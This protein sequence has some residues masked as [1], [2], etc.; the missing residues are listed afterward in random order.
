MT[1][2]FGPAPARRILWV[3][4]HP[5][6]NRHIVAALEGRGL[7]VSYARTTNLAVTLLARNAYLAVI[8]DMGRGEGAREGFHL[9]DVMRSRGDA[10]PLF[11]FAGLSAPALSDE[12]LLHDA[13]GST[14]DAGELL[15]FIDDLVTTKEREHD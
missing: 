12:A 13:Q 10:T 4:D 15:K 8:S 14:N 5:Q 6:N 3:D 1:F 9:L 11:F 2:R 7:H